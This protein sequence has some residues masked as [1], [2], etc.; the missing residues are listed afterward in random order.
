MLDFRKDKINYEILLYN[1]KIELIIRGEESV[2]NRGI[3]IKNKSNNEL[4]KILA[5]IEEFNYS[6]VIAYLKENDI[7]YSEIEFY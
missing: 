5:S 1:G 6:E 4:N 7:S 2:K 3:A